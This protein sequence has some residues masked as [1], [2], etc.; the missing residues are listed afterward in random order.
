MTRIH[1]EAKWLDDA[2]EPEALHNPHTTFRAALLEML[3]NHTLNVIV[4]DGD[5]Y[6][7]VI[8]L[9]RLVAAIALWRDREQPIYKIL[10]EPLKREMQRV[11][12]IVDGMGD[13]EVAE[14]LRKAPAMD[15]FP[16]VKEEKV[17]G[18]L[19][20]REIVAK[21]VSDATLGS[22][23]EPLP[24]VG[25]VGEALMEMKEKGL[26]VVAVEERV[27]D[28]RD[29]A[30]RIWEE[31]TKPIGHV[32]FEDLAVEPY[33]VF[34]DSVKVR[35]ALETLDPHKVDYILVETGE[36]YAVVTLNKLAAHLLHP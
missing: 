27:V 2:R 28:A 12:P 33:E 18:V 15:E 10:L 6:E 21:R 19:P 11:E 31:R 9:P 4:A 7:G 1:K 30:K 24:R 13:K 20:V 14:V 3:T 26:P 23:A 22:L 25:S 32:T 16:I 35:D 5:K 36:G 17:V 34:K 8:T 29:V